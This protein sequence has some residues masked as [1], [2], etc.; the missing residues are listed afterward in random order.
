MTDDTDPID[1][2]FADAISKMEA[3]TGYECRNCG[4]LFESGRDARQHMF[5]DHDDPKGVKRHTEEQ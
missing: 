5:K 2:V 1:E 3:T 4:L